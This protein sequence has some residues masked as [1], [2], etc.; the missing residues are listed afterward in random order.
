MRK[1]PF[2]TSANDHSNISV[3][4]CCQDDDRSYS[5]KESPGAS[6]GNLMERVYNNKNCLGVREISPFQKM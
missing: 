3:C 6:H 4:F 2:P 5:G 1:V